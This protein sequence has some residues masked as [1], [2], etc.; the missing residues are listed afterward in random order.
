MM[1][2]G[3]GARDR[4]ILVIGPATIALLIGVSR[5]APLVHAWEVG[6]RDSA[7]SLAERV[8]MIRDGAHG[9]PLLNDSLR[10]RAARLSA[11]D[12]SL[13]TGTT[14]ASAAA[15][16]AAAIE[17]LADQARMRITA[18]QI[19]SD[20]GSAPGLARV[21]IRLTATAD[22]HGLTVF[23]RAVEGDETPLVVRELTISQPEPTAADT[24]AESLRVDVLIESLSLVVTG[25]RP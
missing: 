8:A 4:R 3:L 7:A 25:V 6:Q 20:T 21:G 16:L 13:I 23:L 18:L 11:L 15:S 9:L 17:D 14:A 5:G 12:S 2:F 24:R 1:S 10:A 19:R 22:I